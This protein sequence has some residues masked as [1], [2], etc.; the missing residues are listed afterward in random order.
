MR[1]S[2]KIAVIANQYTNL[3]CILK[4]TEVIYIAK[5]YFAAPARIYSTNIN[6]ISNHLYD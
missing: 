5:K 6:S 4:Y 3:H 2:D 1:A